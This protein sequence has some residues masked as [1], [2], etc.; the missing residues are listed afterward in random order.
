MLRNIVRRGIRNLGG[1][2][3]NHITNGTTIT[4]FCEERYFLLPKAAT[5][6]EDSRL[7]LSAGRQVVEEHMRELGIG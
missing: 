5:L 7:L 3:P 1:I 2:A 6:E 4:T